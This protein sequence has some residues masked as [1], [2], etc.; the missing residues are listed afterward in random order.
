MFCRHVDGVCV[1][2]GHRVP[3]EL[4]GRPMVRECD[5]MALGDDLE[6]WLTSYGVTKERYVAVK[7]SLGL[8]PTCNCEARKEWLNRASR[9][10]HAKVQDL[11]AAVEHYYSR[12]R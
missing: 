2:C 1:Q 7:Q 9:I 12:P 10:L 5:L 6:R 4:A 11:A 8:P 3:D